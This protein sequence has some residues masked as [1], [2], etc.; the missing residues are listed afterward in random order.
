MDP[1]VIASIITAAASVGTSIFEGWSKSSKKVDEKLDKLVT[2]NYEKLR[3]HI[4]DPCTRILKRSEDR[5]NHVLSD[6]RE[7]AYPGTKF[8]AYT[9]EQQFDEQ[10]KYRLKYLQLV[11]VMSQIGGDYFIT[12]LGLAF[13]R[14]A[15]NRKEYF[16]ILFRQG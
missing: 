1:V 12:P 15:R 3:L 10:F 6:L 8:S 2:E 13:L 7:A 14:E 11:G 5:Q 4:T 16:D 9:D